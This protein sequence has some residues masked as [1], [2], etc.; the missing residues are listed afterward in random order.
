MQVSFAFVKAET[1][2]Y[3]ASG[4][5]DTIFLNYEKAFDITWHRGLLYKSSKSEL[6]TCVIQLINSF[7]SQRKCRVPVVGKMSTPR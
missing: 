6:P 1:A 4:P 7:V 5:R 2:M 3:E